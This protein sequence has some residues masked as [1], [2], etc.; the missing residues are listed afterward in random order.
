MKNDKPVLRWA[1][2]AALLLMLTNCAGPQ[3]VSRYQKALAT[4]TESA[5]DAF[6]RGAYPQALRLYREALAESRAADDPAGIADNAYNAAICLITLKDYADAGPF[7][8]EARA[9]RARLG[10][11]PVEIILV[12]ATLARLRK[13]LDKAGALIQEAGSFLDDEAPVNH[14]I[15]VRLLLAQIACDQPEPV[16]AREALAR[17][18]E[19]LP[20]IE[21]RVVLA[22]AAG[23]AGRVLM[24]EGHPGKAAASFDREAALLKKEGQ[25]RRMALALGHAGIAYRQAKDDTTAYNRLYRAARSLHAQ[26]D[27]LG[28]L[29]MIQ[30]ALPN[31]EN[32]SDPE[33]LR[34]IVPLFKAVKQTVE[35]ADETRKE[36]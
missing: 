22:A 28:A 30:E 18:E 34:G 9:E 27:A 19:L 15:Q 21:D 7:L 36:P 5:R 23:V 24:L 25:F 1:G 26:G 13:D 3:P 12:E 29:T 31:V 17:A 2:A 32:S 10:A 20:A 11:D 33:A 16:A 14:H 35:R 8:A 4:V 6:E